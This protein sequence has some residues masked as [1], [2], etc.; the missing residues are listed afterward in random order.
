[1]LKQSSYAKLFLLKICIK[2]LELKWK[3][4]CQSNLDCFTSNPLWSFKEEKLQNI[5][6]NTDSILDFASL[7]TSHTW[8]PIIRSFSS[9]MN[10][11]YCC[12]PLA[13]SSAAQS[14]AVFQA[15]IWSTWL[16]L[17]FNS[18]CLFV[19]FCIALDR[20][21]VCRCYSTNPPRRSDPLHHLPSPL[22]AAHILISWPNE[23][24]ALSANLNQWESASTLSLFHFS[25]Q[26]S[27]K[28]DFMCSC[29]LLCF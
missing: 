19:L 4:S 17:F 11:T 5:A 14:H 29:P 12:A 8:R 16:S 3:S 1:M 9:R 6:A 18:P 2:P 22:Q 15:L 23:A 13:H 27:H 26:Q 24:G 10:V 7:N 21:V 20:L 25:H 28:S